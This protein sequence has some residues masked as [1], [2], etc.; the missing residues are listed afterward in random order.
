MQIC[1]MAL[2]GRRQCKVDVCVSVCVCV[3]SAVLL[4]SSHAISKPCPL[5]LP[6]CPPFPPTLV[7]SS[8]ASHLDYGSSLPIALPP[9]L[10][11]ITHKSELAEVPGAHTVGRSFCSQRRMPLVSLT[12]T[13]GLW[14][15]PALKCRQH[16]EQ[17]SCGRRNLGP[18]HHC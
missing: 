14:K 2:T 9:P 8:I 11:F 10:Q 6:S 18:Q 4:L 1:T 17:Q 16:Q 5:H 15:G 3:C 7:L 13:L 12:A